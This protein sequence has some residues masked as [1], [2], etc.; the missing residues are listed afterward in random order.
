MVLEHYVQNPMM[1]PNGFFRN[2]LESLTWDSGHFHVWSYKTF[3]APKCQLQ[4]SLTGAELFG[5]RSIS[6][7]SFSKYK[8]DPCMGS[9]CIVSDTHSPD[10]YVT[11]IFQHAIEFTLLI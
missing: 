9:G 6:A 3:A 5:L 11:M 2:K 8:Q 10:F 1:A 7:G 4:N